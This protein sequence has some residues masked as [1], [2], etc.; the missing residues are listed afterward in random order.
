MEPVDGREILREQEQI[1]PV[2]G[3]E[4]KLYKLLN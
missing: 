3:E 2:L 1:L 4:E